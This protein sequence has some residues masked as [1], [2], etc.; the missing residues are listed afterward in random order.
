M[1]V[2]EVIISLGLMFGPTCPDTG[3]R[4]LT[5]NDT[6]VGEF[7]PFMLARAK[8]YGFM[9]DGSYVYA[10]HPV[11]SLE[12]EKMLGGSARNG[13]TDGCINLYHEDFEK[14]PARFKLIIKD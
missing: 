2:Y 6:P 9:V 5:G 4:V 7:Q 13:I 8:G 11:F 10:V 1:I 14:L 3:C 12:R